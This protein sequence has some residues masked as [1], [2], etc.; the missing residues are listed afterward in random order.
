MAAEIDIALICHKGPD[1][2]AAHKEM[3]AR[4]NADPAQREKTREAVA[5]ILALKGR[6][7]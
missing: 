4:I 2:E 7:L 1:I 5:R 6:L 3:L